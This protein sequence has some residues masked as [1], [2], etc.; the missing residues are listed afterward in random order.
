MPP[1]HA[2]SATSGCPEPCPAG[3]WVFSQMET[4]QPFWTT[5]SSVWQWNVFTWNFMCF[6]LC[7]LPLVLSV[8]ITEKS[9]APPSSFP[10]IR[11]L[12]TLVRFS[13]SP[14]VNWDRGSCTKHQGSAPIEKH[15]V[16]SN[17]HLQNYLTAKVNFSPTV[18]WNDRN[19]TFFRAS[20]FHYQFPGFLIQRGKSWQFNL[21]L[22]MPWGQ[23]CFPQIKFLSFQQNTSILQDHFGIFDGPPNLSAK[24]TTAAFRMQFV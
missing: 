16:I 8:G 17:C 23:T 21:E 11:Y 5:C 15:C 20:Q 6:N 10:P 1:P 12:D 4:P 18:H 7:P 9:P 24:P 19:T 3:F 13:L 2:G 14:S 22:W